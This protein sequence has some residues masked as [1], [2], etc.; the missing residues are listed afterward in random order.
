MITATIQGRSANTVT[1]FSVFT[2]NRLGRLRDLVNLLDSN[3]IHV[4][5]LTI[6]DF[7][8]S[9]VIRLVVDDPDQTRTL[10]HDQEIQHT[11]SNIIV[12]EMDAVTQLPQ[13]MSA[14]LEVELHINYLYSF[15]PHPHD[16]SL[17]ALSV[18]DNE[19][20][21]LALKKHQF[22]VLVQSDLSR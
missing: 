21:T 12:V 2:V 11:E 8:D 16:K 1:Q 19:I 3:D 4:L 15:I 10:L 17:L 14:L 22:K 7:T 13:L 6:L 9:A 5:A 20:A 18:E